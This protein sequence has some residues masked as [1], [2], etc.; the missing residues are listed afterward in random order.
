MWTTSKQSSTRLSTMAKWNATSSLPRLRFPQQNRWTCIEPSTRSCH[1]NSALVW[2]E[3]RAESV[4]SLTTAMRTRPSIP[5]PVSTWK[6]GLISS[7]VS[8]TLWF[9]TFCILFIKTNAIN[10]SSSFHFILE[11]F[12]SYIYI[13]HKS[14]IIVSF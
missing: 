10:Q 7:V 3:H 12:R 4:S 14:W 8:I 13:V 11:M 5:R 9:F 1:R 6:S 2:W